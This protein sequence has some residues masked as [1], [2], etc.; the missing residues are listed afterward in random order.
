VDRIHAA[1]DHLS[2]SFLKQ[3]WRERIVM[4]LHV[5]AGQGVKERMEDVLFGR[6]GLLNE[7]AAVTASDRVDFE[8][9]GRARI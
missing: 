1:K 2:S 5:S 3:Y 7:V 4:A 9:F 6:K 8:N